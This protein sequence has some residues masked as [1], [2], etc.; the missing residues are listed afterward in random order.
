MG[1][2]SPETAGEERR[3]HPTKFS[4]GL[5]RGA[6]IVC[7]WEGC[8][9]VVMATNIRALSFFLFLPLVRH[10]GNRRLAAPLPR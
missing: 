6:G 1:G 3:P 7:S 9:V 5:R 8:V 2:A 4:D 10:P